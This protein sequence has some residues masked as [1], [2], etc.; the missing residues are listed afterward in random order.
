MYRIVHSAKSHQRIRRSLQLAALDD[1][2]PDH[3]V[4]AICRDL[5]HRLRRRRLPP[6][7][8]VRSMV[9]RGLLPITPLPPCWRTWADC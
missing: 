5:G 9:Y 8:T 1:L 7:P 3:E 6:G 4:E 2:L